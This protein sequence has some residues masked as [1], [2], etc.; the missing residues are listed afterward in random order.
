MT[1]IIL[2]TCVISE[3]KRLQ[4]SRMVREWLDQQNLDSLFITS[5]VVAELASG[6]ERMPAGRRRADH[7]LWLGGLIRVEFAGRILVFD[8][9]TALIYGR[10]TAAAFAQGRPPNMGDAQIA[11]AAAHAGMVVA[12]RDVTDF[13]PFGIPIVNP[14]VRQS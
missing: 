7:L 14:W 8:T 1:G 6:I 3:P 12:T 11:A 10:L 9:E 4:P 5:T 13:E 2:D